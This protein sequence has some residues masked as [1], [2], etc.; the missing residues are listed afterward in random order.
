MIKKT[1]K[2]MTLILVQV[3]VVVGV[4]E[5][6]ARVLIKENSDG[7]LFTRGRI[8]RPYFYPKNT[9]QKKSLL[10]FLISK[11]PLWAEWNVC[12]IYVSI[13]RI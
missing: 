10:S 5:V 3:I 6:A 2:I 4:T 13:I 8:L 12:V 1:L 11:C 9:F 7:N